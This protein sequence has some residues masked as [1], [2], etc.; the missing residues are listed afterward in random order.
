[1]ECRANI[2]STILSHED[3]TEDEKMAIETLT[4][5]GDYVIKG[6][7][8]DLLRVHFTEESMV[9]TATENRPQKHVII[10]DI[11]EAKDLRDWLTR[12]IAEPV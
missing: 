10:C 1:M 7:G 12:R 5:E 9:I 4:T 2:T 3:K 6:H 11:S 8:G